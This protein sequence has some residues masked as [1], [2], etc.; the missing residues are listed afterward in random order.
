MRRWR[1]GVTVVGLM[2]ASVLAPS[3]ALAH[4]EPP[5]PIN[6]PSVATGPSSVPQYGAS[7]P[8]S[9]PTPT[10]AAQGRP[11]PAAAQ[12]QPRSS[13]PAP[14]V[15]SA[16]PSRSVRPRSAATQTLIVPVAQASP[17]PVQE[18]SQAGVATQLLPAP[19][20]VSRPM[21]PHP[22]HSA[23]IAAAHRRAQARA[24]GS[25]RKADARQAS[26]RLHRKVSPPAVARRPRTAARRAKAGPTWPGISLAALGLLV[27]LGTS[28]VVVRSRRSPG[29]SVAFAA[30]GPQDA[31]EVELQTILAQHRSVDFDSTSA[32]SQRETVT[33]P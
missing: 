21:I 32:G 25:Q 7:Q 14:R 8:V 27:L 3:A 19:V 33:L 29:S 30:P 12:A 4:N 28:I 6:G 23:R 11:R 20:A 17:V 5:I 22:R 24:S 1:L 31:V 18:S 15:A 2:M 26:Q 9:P 16:Q 10:P 13:S